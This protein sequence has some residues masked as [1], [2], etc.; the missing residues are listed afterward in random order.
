[1][2]ASDGDHLGRTSARRHGGRDRRRRGH[3]LVVGGREAAL[4]DLAQDVVDD[5]GRTH[6]GQPGQMVDVSE[7]VAAQPDVV[8]IESAY[9]AGHARKQRHTQCQSGF[10]GL[11]NIGGRAMWKRDGDIEKAGTQKTT[12]LRTSATP[13]RD[14]VELRG[15]EPLTPRLPALCS[16]N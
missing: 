16:P 7:G 12:G 4:E 8:S 13:S 6:S 14:L 9:S 15:F 1:V 10:S 3:V 5:V 2:P 11:C